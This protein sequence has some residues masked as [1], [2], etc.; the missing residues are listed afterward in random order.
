MIF[1]FHNGQVV[2]P[3]GPTGDAD[4][5]IADGIVTAVTPV[6]GTPAD[7]EIDLDG[8]WLLPGFVDT[9]VNGGGGVLF[10]DQVDVEAIAAIG[11]A[12]ARFGTTAFLPTLISDTPAQIAAALA[13]VDTAI[14]QGVAGVVGIHIEGPFINEV[15][16]GIHEAHRIRRLDTDT[17]AT[18]T[19]PHRGRVMLTLAPEL[20]D[21]D[22]IRTLVRHGVIVS[23]GHSDAT[24]DETQRAIGAGLTG[25]T[26]LFNAMSPL[27]HRHPG[28]VGAAFD[29]DVYCGLIVDDVHLHPA[30]VRLA[31]RAKGKERIML[32]TDA[33]PSVGTDVS[34]FMLQGKRI[35]VKDGVCIFEDGTLAGTHLDMA[36]ALR[37]TA[38]VTGLP[39][40]DVSTMASGTPAT[41]LSLRDRIGAIAPGQRADWV[42]MDAGLTPRTTWIGGRTVSEAA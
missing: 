35:A 1:R 18:L 39:V 6:G 2:L 19:A 36:S 7:R 9:Q 13:A 34:E 24:Y 17:L 30:V 15:K 25:F 40:P 11:A 5:M 41:F 4:I 22:D 37:K 23:A 12:H 20:C 16:R 29:S 21:E 31:V 26:H 27:H 32:I 38:Q 14:G 3:D 33:M 42:W 10:N 8:G 28:A